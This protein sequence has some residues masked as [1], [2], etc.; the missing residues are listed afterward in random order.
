[1]TNNISILICSISLAICMG[2]QFFPPVNLPVEDSTV[3]TLDNKVQGA[4]FYSDSELEDGLWLEV[5]RVNE[6]GVVGGYISPTDNY[7]KA[8]IIM[9]P[10]ASTFSDGGAKTKAR[11]WHQFLASIYRREG[12]MTWTLS[13]REC[14]TA[15][16]QGDLFDTIEA[17]DWLERDGKAILGVERIYLIGYSSGATL[18]TMINRQR[19]LTALVSI[20]GVTQSSQFEDSWIIYYPITQLFPNNTGM[21]Q[22]YN[23]LTFYG[24]P[25]SPL[26]DHLDSA[27]HVEEFLSPMLYVHG[28]ED[29]VFFVENTQ[30]VEK[31]YRRLLSEGYTLP[32]IEFLYLWG[33]DHFTPPVDP[34]IIAQILEYFERFEP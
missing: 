19:K 32:E 13:I 28:T 23:T 3:Q 22:L 14:G 16:G 33:R 20:G 6:P 26:W 2:C 18:A 30:A 10:G 24:P 7:R 1:M 8:L 15:F 4:T 9:L 29:F 11:R 5:E 34:E 21:C 31:N 25:G 17:V 27:N 12:Y